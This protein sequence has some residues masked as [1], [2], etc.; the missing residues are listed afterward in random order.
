MVSKAPFHTPD[1]DARQDYR[2][3]AG[4]PAMSQPQMH[5]DMNPFGVRVRES[6]DSAECPDSKPV[7]QLFDVTGSMGDIPRAL[8]AKLPILPESLR[9]SGVTGVQI[10][11]GAVGDEHTD[12]APLQVGQFETDVRIDD[13]LNR[14]WLEGMGGHNGG[15]SYGLA[16]YFM[17]RHTSHDRW[18]RRR[19][20]RS[21]SSW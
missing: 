6:R 2:R 7:A 8:Q 21:V 3:A 14:I 17:A 19:R 15:E 16:L 12:T 4:Q 18:D 1:Y 13:W 20:P 9:L 10:L 5:P 11:S